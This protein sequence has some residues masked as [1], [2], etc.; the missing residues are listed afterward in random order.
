MK[1]NGLFLIFQK[2]MKTAKKQDRRLDGHNEHAYVEA[3]K[4]CLMLG[5]K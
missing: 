5:A 4:D 1:F 3:K 2:N